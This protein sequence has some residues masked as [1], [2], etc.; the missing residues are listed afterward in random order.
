MLNQMAYYGKNEA[1]WK[2]CLAIQIVSFLMLFSV[3]NNAA[4]R[5]KLRRRTYHQRRLQQ[6][7]YGGAERHHYNSVFRHN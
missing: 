5:H 6:L 1:I 3:K 4:T 2:N 7:F